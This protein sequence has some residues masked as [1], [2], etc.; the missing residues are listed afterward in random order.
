MMKVVISLVL[1]VLSFYRAQSQV[2]TLH[3]DK[4]YLVVKDGIQFIANASSM[5][6]EGKSIRNCHQF[7][8]RV[9]LVNKIVLIS[10]A[11]LHAFIL[12]SGLNLKVKERMFEKKEFD[13]DCGFEFMLV[14]NVDV[15]FIKMTKK[16][17]K[18]RVNH[19][20]WLDKFP[21]NSSFIQ[22]GVVLR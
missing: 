14:Q 4:S 21:D 2:D 1:F 11:S 8:R 22:L 20:D 10:P 15:V 6:C 17:Y 19:T 12:K 16:E 3:I 7:K 5:Y 9:K 18:E 13:V